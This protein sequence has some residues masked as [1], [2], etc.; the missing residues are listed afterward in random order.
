MTSQGWI[1]V[2]LDLLQSTVSTKGA[3]ETPAVHG[4]VTQ[5]FILAVKVLVS[6]RSG[7]GWGRVASS[8]RRKVLVTG[9]SLPLSF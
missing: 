9:L 8:Q 5:I 6:S 3:K 2:G 4:N 7:V 1:Y